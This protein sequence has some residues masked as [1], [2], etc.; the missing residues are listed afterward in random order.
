MLARLLG[1]DAAAFSFCAITMVAGFV[2]DV[3]EQGLS[4]FAGASWSRAIEIAWT[5]PAVT[6]L[7]GLWGVVLISPTLLLTLPA[8][9]WAARKLDAAAL[10]TAAIGTVPGLVAGLV[11]FGAAP[12]LGPAILVSRAL[13]GAVF[14]SDN[15]K[16][17]RFQL[18]RTGHR[19]VSR[20]P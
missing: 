20:G 19:P 18:Q 6:G 9:G 7:L 12:R 1:H 4:I 13:S 3:R 10:P 16:R 5:A 8:T 17:R 2:D 15:L 14:S 11:T